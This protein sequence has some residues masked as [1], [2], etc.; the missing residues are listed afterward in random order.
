MKILI[1]ISLIAYFL[2]TLGFWFYLYTKKEKGRKIG[3]SLFGIGFLIQI[4]YLL[5]TVVFHG[6]FPISTISDILFFL[7]MVIGAIFYGFSL[8]KKNLK[9]FGAI[10]APIIVFLIALSLPSYSSSEQVY[11]NIWFYAHVVFSILAYAFIIAA[12]VIAIIYLLTERDLK[13]KNLK[14]FFVSKFSSSLSTLLDLEY[15]ATLMIFIFLS[16]ALITS[17]IW[18]SVYLGKHW[19]WDKKQIMLSI[20]WI[21]Y[22][23]LLQIMLIKH[24]YKKRAS[25]L[26]IVGSILALIA[27]WIIE[28]PNY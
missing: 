24:Q 23:F 1:F 9:E 22:G 16:L 3:F 6:Y 11:D 18:S 13:R 19:L 20:L 10:Y 21:F 28:H 7:S 2:S 8:Y 27:F 25:Y 15:K 26:T 17:S 12:T 14:S 4:V 5:G